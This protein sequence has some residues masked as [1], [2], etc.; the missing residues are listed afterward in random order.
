METPVVI[1]GA[2]VAGLACARDLAAE[3]VAVVVVEKARGVGG[4]CST[5]RIEG[6]PVDFGVVFLH[7]KH[8]GFV[9]EL[10][11]VPGVSILRGWPE[12]V[13]G[14]GLPCQPDAFSPGETR[15]AYREGVSAF[16]KHLATGLNVRLESRVVS[17]SPKGAEILVG[18]EDGTEEAASVLI[19]ALPVEQAAAL[20]APIVD[21]APGLAAAHGVLGMVGSVPCLTLIAGYDPGTPAPAWDVMYPGEASVLGM[22]SHESSKRAGAPHRVVVYQGSPRWSRRRLEDDPEDWSA[23]MLEAAERWVG[24]WARGPLWR[25]SHRWRY[26]RTE[27]GSELAAPMLVSLPGGAR[28][29]LLGEVFSP[30]GGVEAAWLSGRRL[31]SRLLRREGS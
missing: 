1:V 14:T 9:E 12:L 28:V 8:P 26:A 25:Q 15:L 20:L 10:A 17:I 31:A 5:R 6:Q 4:R 21:L 24:S 19:L 29:G 27:R 2:G 13:H 16:P 3:G 30:G 7:G 22:I 23:E 18:L 11:S